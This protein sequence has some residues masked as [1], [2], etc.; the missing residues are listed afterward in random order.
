L[1]R[2]LLASF[3]RHNDVGEHQVYGAV[4]LR[5]DDFCRMSVRTRYYSIS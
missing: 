2:K 1:A 3:P 5:Q 4:G